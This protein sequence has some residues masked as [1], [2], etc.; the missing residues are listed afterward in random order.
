MAA[1]LTS[2]QGDMQCITQTIIALRAPPIE[3]GLRPI[4]SAFFGGTGSGLRDLCSRVPEGTANRAQ[5][6]MRIRSLLDLIS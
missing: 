6:R 3:R 1:P 4:C 2:R 5:E